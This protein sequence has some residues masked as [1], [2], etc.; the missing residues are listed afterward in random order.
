M[1]HKFSHFVIPGSSLAAAFGYAITTVFAQSGEVSQV[2]L[3]DSLI[4]QLPAV[5]AILWLVYCHRQDSKDI[6]SEG[7][8]DRKL[9]TKTIAEMGAEC[10]TVQSRSNATHERTIEA[11]AH[12]S[13]VMEHAIRV[14][15]HKQG[16]G[17]DTLRSE[18]D[19]W[20]QDR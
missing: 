7:I 10:H 13:A 17:P 15:E 4:R 16:N 3:L 12:N 9:F 19:T 14:I 6:R 2:T 11:L 8:A 18:R 1:L 20:E 5:A